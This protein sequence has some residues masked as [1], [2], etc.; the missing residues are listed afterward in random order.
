MENFDQTLAQQ[1]YGRDLAERKNWYAPAAMAYYQSRPHYPSVLID[2]A[3]AIAQLDRHSSILELGCGP[4]I[5]TVD[6]AKKLD[7]Q[8]IGIEPNPD[9]YQLAQQACQPYPNV[10]LE[11]CA[12]EEWE[13]P[14]RQFDAILAA[15]SLHWISPAI[16]YPKMHAALCSAGWLIM[17]WN[18]E[19]QPSNA[20]YQQL[21]EVYAIHAPT[22]VRSYEDTQTQVDI[23]D[24]LGSMAIVSGYFQAVD[25]DWIEVQTTYSIDRYLQLLT[26]YSNHLALA[27]QQQ[28]DLLAGL[29]QVLMQNG[30]CVQLTYVSACQIVRGAM[31]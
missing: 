11:N 4:A 2:R 28:A 26:T 27:P 5:A 30:G 6:F 31:R 10:R 13:L 8:L 21:S 29:K 9:F 3:I 24:R 23:L 16:G 25:S 14:D 12:F 7:C 20:V 18:K 17:L 22:I 1:C 19:L 15:S